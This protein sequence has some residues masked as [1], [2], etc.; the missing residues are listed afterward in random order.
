M[1]RRVNPKSGRAEQSVPG[2][3]RKTVKDVET[4]KTGGYGQRCPY[5]AVGIDTL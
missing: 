2:R 5:P 1:L 4:S 3:G